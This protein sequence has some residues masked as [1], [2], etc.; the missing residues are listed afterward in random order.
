MKRKIL[1]SILILLGFIV[2]LTP[3]Y[4]L[5]VCEYHGFKE[6]SCSITGN[7]EMITGLILMIISLIPIAYKKSLVGIITGGISFILGAMIL[8]IPDITGYCHSE[9]MPCN[10]GTVPFLRLTGSLVM[11]VSLIFLYISIKGYREER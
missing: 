1:P 3:G 9:R 2:L 8:T 6:M 5:P 11:A 7:I 10:Y 4:I